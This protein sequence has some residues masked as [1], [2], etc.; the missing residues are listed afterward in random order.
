VVYLAPMTGSEEL[1]P[2]YLGEGMKKKETKL[3]I[4]E[5][6]ILLK[7]MLEQEAE[8]DKGL[9]VSPG[10]ISERQLHFKSEKGVIYGKELSW[11]EVHRQSGALLIGG[12]GVMVMYPNGIRLEQGELVEMR[13]FSRAQDSKKQKDEVRFYGEG[14]TCDLGKFASSSV[15]QRELQKQIKEGLPKA[16]IG[17]DKAFEELVNQADGWMKEAYRMEFPR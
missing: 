13:V 12:A 16:L 14:V 5:S 2:Y 17:R 7:R 11:R 6:F 4:A 15:S 1:R 3:R 8:N 10:G 9:D